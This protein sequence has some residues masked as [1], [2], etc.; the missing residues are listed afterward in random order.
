[1]NEVEMMV[2]AMRTKAKG[3]MRAVILRC[4]LKAGLEGWGPSPFEAG[5]LR[6]LA[7][8]GDGIRKTIS[9]E[10]AARPLCTPRQRPVDHANR[11]RE[12]VHRNERTKAWAFL[13]AEQHLVEHVEPI[14]R[15]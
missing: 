10:I 14:E 2:Q 1:M 4:R 6:S 15:D 12:P 7:P 11:V 9:I 8:Q 3:V 13:L 5:E